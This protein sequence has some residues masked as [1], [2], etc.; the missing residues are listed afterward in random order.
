MVPSIVGAQ[1]QTHI[2]VKGDTLWDICEKYYGDPNLWPKLWEMNPFVTNPHLLEPGDVINLLEG[3]PI[4]G[5]KPLEEVKEI[6]EPA[7]TGMGID[8]SVLTNVK[9][10]G[11]LSRKKLIPWGTIFTGDTNRIVLAEGDTAYLFFAPDK[12]PKPGD[13]FTICKSSSLLWHPLTGRRLGYVISFLGLLAVRE[14]VEGSIYKAEILETYES[15]KIGDMAI[16]YDP[17][18]P[19][20]QLRSMNPKMI[21]NIVA[22]RD[23]KVIIGRNSVV[24]LDSGFN[25]GI[26]RGGIF[27]VI[28]RRKVRDPHIKGEM[29]LEYFKEKIEL[30]ARLLG[31]AI[32]LESR[33]DTA[34]ALVLSAEEEFKRGVSIRGLSWVETPEFITLIPTCQIE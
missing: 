17:V 30:P 9:D 20:V 22:T 19:C 3:V 11:F 13:V 18:S 4:K 16:P 12:N 2:V 34:T 25:Q 28:E 10:L 23:N 26:H 29:V 7:P 31:R 27:E 15:V 32:I 6:P 5:M 21:E 24:Y 8:V 14:P 33:P 1:P